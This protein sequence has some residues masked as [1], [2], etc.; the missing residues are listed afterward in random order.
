MNSKVKKLNKKKII[1]ASRSPRRIKLLKEAGL[2]FKAIKSKIDEHLI[3]K[4][5]KGKNYKK[6]AKILA[7]SKA[8]SV[9]G[10]IV[11]GFDTIVVC[12]N[13]II[14]KP[15]NNK[16]ALKKLLFLSGKN[17][18]VITGI[19]IVGACHGAPL[20]DCDTTI[21]QMKKISK[22][23]ALNYIKTKEPFDKAGAYAIQGKGR[24]FIKFIKGDYYNV[25]GL[26]LRRL[27]AMF[28]A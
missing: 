21:V 5:F 11:I 6:L 18:K 1:L 4:K 24:K 10:D 20:Q 16:D 13:K 3:T 12:K 19:C 23:D 15:K 7:Y 9:K 17:H 22:Q 2:K 8:I 25:V 14:D 28:K 26:P 27:F